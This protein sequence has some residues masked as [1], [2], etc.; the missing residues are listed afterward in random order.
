M[1]A[2][3]NN[4]LLG[5]PRS[6]SWSF[7][8][9]SVLGHALFCALML[10]FLER[11]KNPSTF[12]QKPIRASLVRLGKPRDPS[13]LPRQETPLPPP[14][15]TALAVRSP[16]PTPPTPPVSV[17][18]PQATATLAK[19]ALAAKTAGPPADH[20]EKLWSAFSRE[21]KAS[22]PLQGQADGD[23]MGDSSVQEG[24]RYFGLLSTAIRRHYDVSATIPENQRSGLKATALIR[25]AS[26]G[27]LLESKLTQPSN[28]PLF[29]A[30]VESAVLR[31]APFPPPP[32]H[33]KE[34]LRK[35]GVPLLFT[36][37]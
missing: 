18:S 24:E 15:S 28:N 7:I 34:S 21:G 35:D 16:A 20:S 22:E 33:L 14:P 32:E 27:K 23:P 12:V 17:P 4:S 2:H 31:A 10:G 11:K 1:A 37:F 29:N 5:S 25:I 36:P 9:I 8:A 30:A 26:N 13:L 3:V 6:L 19:A